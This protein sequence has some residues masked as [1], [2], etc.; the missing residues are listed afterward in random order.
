M[1]QLHPHRR[2]HA[3]YLKRATAL[4]DA[5]TSRTRSSD[6]ALMAACGVARDVLGLV[7]HPT[8]V[9]AA[10]ALMDG[11][12]V[13]MKTGEGKTLALFLA[14]ASLAAAGQHVT[15]LTANDYLSE[16]DATSLA[17]AYAALGLRVGL[18]LPRAELDAKRVAYRSHVVY[19]SLREAAFD[20]MRDGLRRRPWSVVQEHH[21]VALL[22]ELDAALIDH[23]T[24][25]FTIGRE[26][27]VEDDAAIIWADDAV[28]GLVPERDYV[29]DGASVAVTED[30][31]RR[32]EDTLRRVGAL[33]PNERLFERP[34]AELEHRLV[35][36][37]TAHVALERDR[38]YVVD[39][40]SVLLLDAAT[41][42][43]AGG[44]RWSQGLHQAVERK[45][46][47]QLTSPRTSNATLT[48]AA[49]LRRYRHLG[50]ASGTLTSAEEEIHERFGMSTVAMPPHRPSR[51]VDHPDRVFASDAE[52]LAAA[53]AELA[54]PER[55]NQ[56]VLVG[57]WSVAEASAV[58]RALGRAGVSHETLTAH[59]E[60]RE[61]AIIAD[62]GAPGRITVATQL[63]GR[64]TDIVLGGAG[65]AI[66]AEPHQRVHEA[67][68]LR[69]LLL[70]RGRSRRHDDQWRGRCGRRGD[71]GECQV[72]LS[73]GDALMR[74]A[75]GQTVDRAQRRAE[76]Q[77]TAVRREFHALD[78]VIDAQ[79]QAF[80]AMRDDIL[81][82]L[83]AAQSE[84]CAIWWRAPGRVAEQPFT[85]EHPLDA[86]WLGAVSPGV[87][88][89][90]KR[91]GN[92]P[93]AQF[94]GDLLAMYGVA[95]RPR[96]VD[97]QPQPLRLVGQ[98]V[99]LGMQ[100]NA[101]RTRGMLAHAM[102]SGPKDTVAA[103]ERAG[104]WLDERFRA[105]KP[106]HVLR[107]SR[108]LSLQAYDE[109]WTSFLAGVPLLKDRAITES[110]GRQQPAQLLQTLAHEALT[111]ELDQAD[112]HVGHTLLSTGE[113]ITRA[114]VDAT[115][116]RWLRPA[117]A[118]PE[119]S[120]A[121][122]TSARELEAP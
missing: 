68:G 62:A 28:T 121:P 93:L 47:V 27:T 39:G 80:L 7:P 103:S 122:A 55:G 17:P 100:R 48:V 106:R 54:R 74:E 60:A 90:A 37:V 118:G 22:D 109:A 46:R 51:R 31:W 18:A 70:G 87:V 6:A 114:H 14:A 113:R 98:L 107:L 43:I 117:I 84:A 85:P 15:V 108:V 12:A 96:H 13:E 115:A 36:A 57:T 120:P 65:S 1:F 112:L 111:D 91:A 50:G 33:G 5:R 11:H 61:A 77:L 34:D 41:G 49:F 79:R 101:E 104:R 4:L 119:G 71:P 53:V 32:V 66:D 82:G 9:A 58:S 44:R 59:D 24:V 64:G 92:P 35:N 29:R 45:E 25:P 38:D 2:R 67:G 20:A 94:V 75:D 16:R 8:Q 21:D 52:R 86:W 3:P 19:V 102:S 72:W 95:V 30:G 26:A 78:A 10:L 63:A 23:A 83:S 73:A 89:A 116:L 76:S 40:Q 99:R 56:P 69:V 105:S 110:V 97:G 88:R 81:W 42:R